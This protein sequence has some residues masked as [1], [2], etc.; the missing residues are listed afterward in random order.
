MSDRRNALRIILPALVVLALAA[1]VLAALASTPTDGPVPQAQAA[2]TEAVRLR[3][4]LTSANASVAIA[5]DR[6]AALEREVE[7]LDVTVGNLTDKLEGATG[8]AVSIDASGAVTLEYPP[9]SEPKPAPAPRTSAT[10]GGGW[11]T[12]SASWYGP[13]LYG[14]TTAD[15]TLFTADTWCVAHKT[16]PFGTVVQ[17]RYG[18]KTVDVPV[19]DRGP[20]TPGREFDLSAAV[21]RSLGFS[22]VH[23]IE[24]RVRP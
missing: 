5:A 3:Y 10:T 7:L 22:G 23:P 6:A 4:A 21:A 14:N 19:R 15:G 11:K 8:A 20:F 2:D 1:L 24:W 12:A 17:I 16:L 18:G 9:R 13:G